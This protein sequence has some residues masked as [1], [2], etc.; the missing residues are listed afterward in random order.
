MEHSNFFYGLK[1][2][3]SFEIPIYERKVFYKVKISCRWKKLLSHLVKCGETFT[4][5]FRQKKGVEK[6]EQDDLR[7]MVSGS[8]G[9]KDIASLGSEIETI[10]SVKI[11]LNYSEEEESEFHFPSPPCGFR[12]IVPYQ[13]QRIIEINYQDNRIFRKS[14]WTTTVEYWEPEIIEMGEQFPVL[15]DCGCPNLVE[16]K[17]AESHKIYVSIGSIELATNY[18]ITEK[19]IFIPLLNL[20]LESLSVDFVHFQRSM[21]RHDIPDYLLF[22]SDEGRTKLEASFTTVIP[23]EIEQSS[24]YDVV[25]KDSGTRKIEVIK[26]I[27]ALTNLGLV[28]AKSMSETSGSKVLSAIGREEAMKAKEK[29]E[30]AGAEIDLNEFPKNLEN[31]I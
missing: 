9:I 25:L 21:N 19:G 23:P 18:F 30:N 1:E 16:E 5:T 2:E 26:V 22:L 8:L 29:L 31:E 24:A 11:N 6:T 10:S 28:E 13:F 7:S 14:N 20:T 3:A 4:Y 12:T 15:E 17:S 27:R